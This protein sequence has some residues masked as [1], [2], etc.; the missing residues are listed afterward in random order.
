MLMKVIQSS[1][2]YTRCFTGFTSFILPATYR[3]REPWDPCFVIPV[4]PRLEVTCMARL[5]E[6]CGAGA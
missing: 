1:R 4:L 5:L 2:Y 6:S 3:G